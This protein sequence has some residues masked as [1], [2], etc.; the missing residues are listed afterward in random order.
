MPRLIKRTELDF[1]K[2]LHRLIAHGNNQT[3]CARELEVAD[4][5]ITYRLRKHDLVAVKGL[6]LLDK[7][8]KPFTDRLD[9]D[10]YS[11]RE[12]EP[13]QEEVPA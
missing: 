8:G 2:Q 5:T 13:L 9:S 12:D 3:D 1:L 6:G 11:V 7:D 4:G 10:F